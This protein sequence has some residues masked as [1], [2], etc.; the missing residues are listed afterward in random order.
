LKE[1]I[2]VYKTHFDIGY[3]DLARNV[4][5][6]YRTEMLDH[7]LDNIEKHA[8]NP[9]NRQFVWTIP[10]WPMKQILIRKKSG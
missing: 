2:I 8:R 5:H 1:V 3:S 6:K 4:D 10:G 9:K 7:A